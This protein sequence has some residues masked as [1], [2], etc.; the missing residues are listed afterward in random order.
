MRNR[1]LALLL[2]TLLLLAL[3]PTAAFAE[4]ASLHK[5]TFV[6]T[7]TDGK[8]VD[9]SMASCSL[10]GADG[11]VYKPA[12]DE[13][14]WE[15]NFYLLPDGVYD[16]HFVYSQK[17]QGSG[18]ITVAGADQTV[19]VQLE[20][21]YYPIT[22]AVQP[23]NADIKLYK[24]S[25][26]GAYGDPIQPNE[27]GVYAIPFG[28]YRY[29]VSA[30]GYETLEKTFNAT[31]T[32]LKN[33][34]YVIRVQLVSQAE[35][36]LRTAC[37]ELESA[38][39]YP[40]LLSEFTGNL[41]EYGDT[42]IP[43]ALDSDYDDVNVLDYA[44]SILAEA[45]IAG[46]TLRIERVYRNAWY[47]DDSDEAED[48]RI[49]GAD[50]AIRY[51][52]VDADTL[53]EDVELEN[54]YANGA[55]CST[56]FSLQY[57][58]I[59]YS[60]TVE[61]DFVVPAHT[62]TRQERLA[63]A[64][65]LAVSGI[66]AVTEENLT[67]P[68]LAEDDFWGELSINTEWESSRPDVIAPDGSVT[69]PAEDTTLTLTLRAF[70]IDWLCED[71][72]FLYDP[73]PFGEDELRT[74][75]VTV[76]GNSYDV[77]VENSFAENSGA[78]RHQAGTVVEL[79]AGEREGLLFAGWVTED[80]VEIIDADRPDASFLM[81]GHAV[82]VTANWRRK[83]SDGGFSDLPIL[84]IIPAQPGTPAPSEPDPDVDLPDEPDEPEAPVNPFD[85]VAPTDPFYADVLFCLERSL[86]LGVS[87]TAFEP[88][89]GTTRAMLVT[90][91]WRMEGSPVT[92]DANRFDD[93][94]DG[95]W[96]TDA[97]RWA[98]ANGIVLGYGDGRFGPDDSITREQLAA[99]L[100]RYAKYAGI[101]LSEDAVVFEDDAELSDW[102]RADVSR[103]C[104][105][106]ILRADH[107][108]Y[109][110]PQSD[111]LRHQIASALH[112]LTLLS[113]N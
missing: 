16:Y 109:F 69:R 98:S 82:T 9:L 97:V 99:I 35:K 65:D 3:L 11:K 74:V 24:N 17:E 45:G 67:L 84:P 58:D 53:L 7:K 105:S 77:T 47:Y 34:G 94:A 71:K 25:W 103:L 92:E 28:Q 62:M 68:V 36:L 88:Y 76:P 87:D 57:G 30:E 50:G 73:G 101:T 46:V 4:D 27:N 12:E 89:S 19:P 63:Q 8:T 91:L 33:N 52:A 80:D 10:T 14:G 43:W 110:A 1:M 37:R 48:Y 42:F 72:G 113:E 112:A 60:D 106:G 96:Y 5:I 70:Y 64:A 22:F 39:G 95:Q 54:G 23:E 49:I 18:T 86:M 107:D 90:V 40:I 41:Y 29:F 81:P 55:V 108:T 32:A 44:N 6:L 79:H 15:E 2:T 20:T 51:D 56:V 59:V 102:A 78:G 61:M 93:V 13:Y 85:D 26:K 75:T 104:A 21:I 83:P 38:A 100:A 31:D 66:P 111:A